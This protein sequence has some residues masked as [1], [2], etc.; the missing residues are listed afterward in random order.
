MGIDRRVFGRGDV[1]SLREI[2]DYLASEPGV[3]VEVAD[4]TTSAWPTIP[5]EALDQAT[6][7]QITVTRGSIEHAVNWKILLIEPD[8]FA[9]D[10]LEEVKLNLTYQG[11]EFDDLSP[12][13]CWVI[14]IRT[15][16]FNDDVLAVERRLLAERGAFL[17]IEGRGIFNRNGDHVMKLG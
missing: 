4:T 13:I 14:S 7:C 6:D 16:P 3:M 2:V 17:Y 9:N 10:M 5:Y 12:D 11:K 1:P 8:T 15:P